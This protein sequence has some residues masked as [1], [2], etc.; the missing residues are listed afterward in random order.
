[1]ARQGDHHPSSLTNPSPGAPFTWRLRLTMKKS[2][3]MCFNSSARC[4]DLW[5]DGMYSFLQNAWTDGTVDSRNVATL[6]F[7]VAVTNIADTP[8]VFISVPPITRMAQTS[9]PGDFVLSVA[10][11]D[12]DAGP[13]RPIR[14]W[15]PKIK[16]LSW[17]ISFSF[18]DTSWTLVTAVLESSFVLTLCRVEWLSDVPW[19]SSIQIRRL[20][21][22]SSG[23]LHKR[24]EIQNSLPIHIEKKMPEWKLW[25][26]GVVN[27]LW[28]L[29]FMV[30]SLTT[31]LPSY[32]LFFLSSN[33]NHSW[34]LT[35]RLKKQTLWRAEQTSLTTRVR[36]SRLPSLSMMLSTGLR[37]S[38]KRREF[39]RMDGWSCHT[40]LLMNGWRYRCIEGQRQ[41]S[42][43]AGQV[44]V[45][46]AGGFYCIG[47]S[48]VESW[49]SSG[50]ETARHVCVC[51]VESH[52]G[53]TTCSK[54]R[55]VLLR[56]LHN[57]VLL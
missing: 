53:A 1:M 10:A 12:G 20:L 41:G 32:P 5:P 29:L 7:V 17:L 46:G 4:V 28:P 54:T 52:A 21:R 26:I 15:N 55:N 13:G 27:Q 14:W 24:S 56:L 18:P 23:S 45:G 49:L 43:F 30:F 6:E 2:P 48:N 33:S 11:K 35:H 47:R 39:F 8:P 44:Y 51:L 40:T 3:L 50:L 31:A 25:G 36:Q 38:S 34:W 22:S 37:G 19:R 9:L 16:K 57:Q 42:N